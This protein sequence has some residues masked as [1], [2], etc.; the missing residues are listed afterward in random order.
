MKGN[1]FMDGTPHVTQCPILPSA[2]FVMKFKAQEKASTSLV[3]LWTEK[4][5][6]Y[7]EI[8]LQICPTHFQSLGAEWFLPYV[9]IWQPESKLPTS[10]VP[11]THFWHSHVSFQRGDGAFGGYVVRQESTSISHIVTYQYI[12]FIKYILARL[13]LCNAENIRIRILTNEAL[14]S[15]PW[16]RPPWCS[17]W[18]G[19]DGAYYLCSRV[20]SH[21]ESVF[22]F[23]T[24]SFLN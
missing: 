23:V 22:F 4:C 12:K 17:L 9:K 1:Q 7:L 19:P 8:L 11:G 10:Q 20:L 5:K 13:T 21:R 6:K 24:G 14:L 18:W 16:S 15:A 2:K 3:W